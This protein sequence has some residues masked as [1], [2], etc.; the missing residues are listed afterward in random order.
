MD[1]A[2]EEV[3]RIGGLETEQQYPYDG[4]QETVSY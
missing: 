3:I 4:V 1:Q 2:F